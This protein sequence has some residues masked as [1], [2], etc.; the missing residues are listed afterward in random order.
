M[1]R[2]LLINYKFHTTKKT[3]TRTGKTKNLEWSIMKLKITLQQVLY[4]TNI[5]LFLLSL[6]KFLYKFTK[7]KWKLNLLHN[8]HT[9]ILKNKTSK[10]YFQVSKDFTNN[11]EDYYHFGDENS[12]GVKKRRTRYVCCYRDPSRENGTELGRPFVLTPEIYDVYN[13]YWVCGV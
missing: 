8:N 11:Y 13:S 7:I 1:N 3:I 10:I 2:L 12:A 9:G 6:N 4:Y 5:S